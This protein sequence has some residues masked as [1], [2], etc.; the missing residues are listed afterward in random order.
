M[1]LPG[2]PDTVTRSDGLIRRLHAD[3]KCQ[4]QKQKKKVQ[5]TSGTPYA[6][7]PRRSTDEEEE[8]LKHAS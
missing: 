3:R 6:I 7:A 4:N 1:I 2:N 5:P 8:T